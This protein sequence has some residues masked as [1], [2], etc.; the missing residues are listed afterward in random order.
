M[1]AF[2]IEQLIQNNHTLNNKIQLWIFFNLPDLKFDQLKT[3]SHLWFVY[4]FWQ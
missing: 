3:Y 2:T 4:S 1:Y